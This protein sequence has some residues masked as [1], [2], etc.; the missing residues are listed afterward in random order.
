MITG[1][2]ASNIE[3]DVPPLEEQ[4]RIADILDKVTD[5]INKR[6]AQLDKLDLLVKSRFIEMFGDLARADCPY[7]KYK[8]VDVCENSD[9]IKCGP[10]GTQLSKDEYQDNGVALWEIPQINSYFST[11]PTHF[12]TKEK[13]EQLK[14]F[15]I[16]PGDIVM[17][18]KGNVGRCALFPSDF[19]NG[20]MHSDVLRIRIDKQRVNPCFM[21]YQLHFSRAVQ[22]QIE[23]V[24]SGAIMAGVNVTKLK[25]IEVHLPDFA[26]QES[27][28]LFASKYDDLKNSIN[29][30]LKYLEKA[31]QSLMQKY[32]G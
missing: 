25:N 1:Y 29:E 15:S 12:L 20:V 7:R 28:C 2:F 4:H 24:S 10:F 18:R 9:D 11:K 26:L 5:L 14:M 31:R 27:F 19:D 13:A 23:M 30:S 3:I 22:H 21:V 6:R 32:F 17:S 8:L 16:I